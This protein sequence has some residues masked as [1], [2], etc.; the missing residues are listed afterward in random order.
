[1]TCREQEE[2][3]GLWVGGDLPDEDAA[4]IEAHMGVCEVCRALGEEMRACRAVLAELREAPA[5][6]VRAE[7]M[8]RLARRRR[9]WIW[10]RPAAAALAASLAGIAVWLQGLDTR[11]PPQPAAPAVRASVPPKALELSPRPRS[12]P[13]AP[14][15]RPPPAEAEETFTV[16]LVTE[17]P[18]IVIYWLFAKTGD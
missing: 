5:M 9:M 18:D 17:D 4:Q 10:G 8:E 16:K 15:R 1:M 12:I 3:I 2:R 13:R 14:S 7:V 6:S 11:I